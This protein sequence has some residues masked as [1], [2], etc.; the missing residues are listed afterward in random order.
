ME[1][2]EWLVGNLAREVVDF[3]KYWK[4][5]LVIER[6]SDVARGRRNQHEFVHRRFLKAVK[7][8]AKR[9]GIEV[10]EVNPAYTSVIGGHKYAPYY[11]ITIHQAAALVVARR[12]QGFSER[13]RGLKSLLFEARK[14]GEGNE[15]APSRR[16][17]SWS[18][19]R[20][21]RDLPSRKGT[22]RK[23]PGQS[24]ETTGESLGTSGPTERSLGGNDTPRREIAS[25]S[26]GPPTQKEVVA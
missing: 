4:R 12:G 24:H 22:D 1:K 15:G 19:W 7:R 13:L 17:H 20:L 9:E 14:A 6:L 16:V 21:M 11:H 23:H 3:A 2:R 8:R 5:G 25:P 26:S 10:R 18:L